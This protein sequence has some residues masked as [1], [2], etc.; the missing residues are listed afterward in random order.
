MNFKN[1]NKNR[2]Y[3]LNEI[4]EERKK[5]VTLGSIWQTLI[6]Y[7]LTA[8]T[9]QSID[10]YI[11][12]LRVCVFLCPNYTHFICTEFGK[13]FAVDFVFS[14]LHLLFLYIICFALCSLT[15]NRI[16]CVLKFFDFLLLSF[17]CYWLKVV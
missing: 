14:L 13:S 5:Y 6:D 16:P 15:S 8:L 2:F 7:Y 9:S 17:Y 10:F 3:P 11:F 12:I 1:G 4:I